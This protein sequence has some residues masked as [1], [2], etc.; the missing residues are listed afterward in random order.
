M[1]VFHA[2]GTHTMLM[3]KHESEDENVPEYALK[4]AMLAVLC[5]APEFEVLRNE[6]A[7]K[8]ADMV[9]VFVELQGRSGAAETDGTA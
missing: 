6:V 3:P 9:G 8:F 4:A 1:L 7:Q 5:T 2:D